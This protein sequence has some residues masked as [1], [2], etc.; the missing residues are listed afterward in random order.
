MSG[1]GGDALSIARERGAHFK[2]LGE[3]GLID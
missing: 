1:A 3:L 2:L